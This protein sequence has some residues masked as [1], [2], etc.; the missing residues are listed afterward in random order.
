M[1]FI[2]DSGHHRLIAIDLDGNVIDA[3]EKNGSRFVFPNDL[4]FQ[5]SSL[6][7][8]DTNNS[9]VVAIDVTGG[10]FGRDLWQF[11][12]RTDLAGSGRWWP[13]SI[14]QSGNGDW[15]VINA[16][17]GMRHGVV[18]IFEQSGKAIRSVQ[19]PSAP[20]ILQL[21]SLSPALAKLWEASILGLVHDPLALAKVGDQILVTDPSLMRVVSITQDGA[22][23]SEFGDESFQAELRQLSERRQRLKLRRT[24]SMALAFALL[25]VAVPIAKRTKKQKSTRTESS[26][27]IAAVEQHIAGYKTPVTLR[28]N[29]ERARRLVLAYR[30]YGAALI[31][32]PVIFGM[33][34]PE[35]FASSSLRNLTFQ[36]VM[37]LD[38]FVVGALMLLMAV[39]ISRFAK[40]KIVVALNAVHLIEFDGKKSSY[41]LS[42]IVFS[43][44]IL[45]IGEQFFDP[46]HRPYYGRSR[47][48]LVCRSGHRQRSRVG[49]AAIRSCS[50]RWHH[51]SCRRPERDLALGRS[52]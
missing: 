43:E 45:R 4:M 38:S 41:P 44:R 2:S 5:S 42:G 1:I 40:L 20:S 46:F 27:R 7:A 8:A 33:L 22:H 11:D 37:V 16:G 51:R 9:R 24:G 28:A 32:M 52:L 12:A 31:A 29:L 49:A 48:H 14:A 17:A 18:L 47:R 34:F 15:W 39:R 30:T 25:M 23:A 10:R 19:L 13:M 21:D 36:S 50:T 3:T 6:I 35:F 26:A